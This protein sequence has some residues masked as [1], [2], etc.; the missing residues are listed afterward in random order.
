MKPYCFIIMPFGR[1]TDESGRVVEFDQ[2]YD[3]IIKPAVEE[4]GLNPIRADEEFLGGIIHKSMFERLIICEYAIADLTTANANVFYELGVRHGIRPHSTILTFA[5]GMRLPFD[6]ALLRALPYKLDSFGIPVEADIH[7]KKI[8]ERLKECRNPIDDSPVFQL[9]SNIPRINI[10]RLK[11]DTF[12]DTVEYS[13]DMKNRLRMA[14]SKNSNEV[15]KI[16]QELGSIIDVDFGIIIDLFLSYRAVE[17]WQSMVN[18]VSNMP[19]ML[20][21]TVLVQEQLGFAHNRLD[22]H[23]EAE[24]VLTTVISKYGASSETNG[25]L[26][27][28]YKDL[29]KKNVEAGQTRIADGF[30]QKAIESYLQGFEAD[31]RD[32]YPGV[33]AVTLMEMTEPVDRRQEHLLPVVR[34]AVER[35]L[36]AKHPDYWDF[37]TLLELNVLLRDQIQANKSLSKALTEIRETWEPK[38]TANNINMIRKVRKL[39]GEKVEWIEEIE[40]ELIQAGESK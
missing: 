11:T 23:T 39:R 28:V 27:R 16:E 20:I 26:G 36:A 9:V 17:D 30:L 25:I 37:A 13:H 40:I 35:R 29:W 18:L 8:M 10:A 38:T 2:V 24:H 15:A 34:Y 5:K 4:A 21:Q 32:A 33:N 3:T 12:R 19:P 31:W 1:K 6:V 7:R 14:R 22:N